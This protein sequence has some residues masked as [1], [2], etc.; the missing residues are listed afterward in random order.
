MLRTKC[1]V[2]DSEKLKQ[3]IDLGSHPFADT[4]IPESRIS[5]PDVTFPLVCDLCLDCGHVQTRYETSPL[6]R[7]SQIDYSY[8]S[9]NSAFSRNHWEEYAKEISNELDIKLNSFI[10][11]IGSNDGYLSEQF[12]KSGNDVLGVDPSPYMAKLAKERKVETIVGLFDDHISEEILAKHKK[13]DLVIANNVFNHADNPLEFAKAVAKILDSKGSFVFEQPYWV[14]TIKTGKFDQVYHEHVSYFTVKS[15]KELLSR[16]GLVI[17]SAQVVD[18]HGGSLRIIAQKKENLIVECIQSKNM[19]KEEEHYGTYKIETYEKFMKKILNQR[20]EF[21]QKI[22]QLKIEGNYIVAVGA[23][24]KANI[25]LNF[26]KLDNSFIDYVTDASPYKKGKY[27]PSTRIPIVGDEIFNKYKSVYALI[28]SWNIAPQLKE[29]L[30]PINPNI[31][32]IAP[33]E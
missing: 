8:T 7:Y 10:V 6:A 22:C 16:A 20:N 23:A 25:F 21:L 26:Y 4:F 5:E 30:A 17:R 29:K 18:Y 33:K 31:Q 24:A 3:I 11:E 32:F 12:L 1:L 27:T 2:C 28:L 9:S 19:I 13:A 14:E 15:V